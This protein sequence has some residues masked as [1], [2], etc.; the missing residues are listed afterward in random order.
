[1]GTW[2][3]IGFLVPGSCSHTSAGYPEAMPHRLSWSGAPHRDWP[4]IRLCISLSLYC[5]IH[6]YATLSLSLSLSLYIYIYNIQLQL[7]QSTMLHCS[8]LHG[9]T[10]PGQTRPCHN[11]LSLPPSPSAL[12]EGRLRAVPYPFRLHA[13][14]CGPLPQLCF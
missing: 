10:I 6:Y 4:H 8:T 5:A 1:M 13:D 3:L 12:T 2:A 14:P 7:I 11:I 9:C